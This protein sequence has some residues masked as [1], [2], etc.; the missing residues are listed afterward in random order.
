MNQICICTFVSEFEDPISNMF[1]I[2][3]T[4]LCLTDYHAIAKAIDHIRSS[5]KKQGGSIKRNKKYVPSRLKEV[6]LILLKNNIQ[7]LHLYFT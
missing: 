5:F 7:V 1:E 3:K 4:E 6:S 2:I